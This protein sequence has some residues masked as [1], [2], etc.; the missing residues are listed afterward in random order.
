NLLW[1]RLFGGTGAD[2]AVEIKPAAS[3]G[4]YVSG[5][6]NSHDG[7]LPPNAPEGYWLLKLNEDGTINW[8]FNIETV[9]TLN[10]SAA[11]PF[12]PLAD[13]GCLFG[14]YRLDAG[15][16]VVGE[17]PNLKDVAELPDGSLVGVNTWSIGG[18]GGGGGTTSTV[19]ATYGINSN[20]ETLWETPQSGE[21]IRHL[22]DG[23]FLIAGIDRKS[24]W[25][26]NG[27]WS[28]FAFFLKKFKSPAP[29]SGV[30]LPDTLYACLETPYLLETNEPDLSHL[31]STGDTTTSISISEPGTYS[32]ILD[33]NAGCAE[34][35]I[36]EVI[37]AP[38]GCL[39]SDTIPV[40]LCEGD[41]WLGNIF[42]KDTVVTDTV[43]HVGETMIHTYEIT[44]IETPETS[45]FIEA[46]PEE[47]PFTL[48]GIAFYD[49]GNYT[50]YLPSADACDSV[51]QLDLR[52]FPA[53]EP[54]VIDTAVVVG[55]EIAGVPVF[56]DSVFSVSFVDING[57]DSLVLFNVS[58]YTATRKIPETALIPVV[59]PN[60]FD[61]YF[62]IQTTGENQYLRDIRVFNA[63]G[64][65][66]FASAADAPNAQ[67]LTVQTANWTPG[68]YWIVVKTNAG[69]Y[70]KYVAKFR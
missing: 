18:G 19:G 36:F 44:I 16:N 23:N 52:F 68:L 67:S 60:P 37:S 58:T 4:Y 24:T 47:A 33:N 1:S 53:H 63:L 15:G 13:G 43:F 70:T 11:Q 41:T 32:L 64:Q 21:I 22:L 39:A 17:Y 50:V 25:S 54:T 57:C 26:T 40:T 61:E 65:P 29:V 56:S 28:H 59:F 9:F 7:T 51:L 49:T 34:T 66:V 12:R 6:S 27:G 3:G 14:K 31:W 20:G 55:S 46:C 69:V 35:R 2:W 30:S 48:A 5:L 8:S 62:V 45:V 38:P 10:L 42:P